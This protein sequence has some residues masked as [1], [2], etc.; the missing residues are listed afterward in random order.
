MGTSLGAMT[1]QENSP[2]IRDSRADERDQF[3]V[4]WQAELNRL[5]YKD[6]TKEEFFLG[7]VHYEKMNVYQ[8]ACIS[9]Y[10]WLGP[11]ETAHIDVIRGGFRTSGIVS[12]DSS[13]G[14]D[15]TRDGSVSEI[16]CDR[17]R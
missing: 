13:T 3:R 9:I 15:G 11:N 14:T 17:A 7:V 16:P 5:E 10:L 6:N 1:A 8:D 12:G 2:V 4:D